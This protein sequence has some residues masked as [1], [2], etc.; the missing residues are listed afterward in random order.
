MIS[1]RSPRA[2]PLLV[3]GTMFMEQLDGTILVTALP[4]IAHSF[5]VT[6]AE[7]DL[8]VSGYL[9][10]LAVM[11]PASG[12]IAD[13]FGA[14]R[15]FAISIGI[16]VLA[17]I[18]C[19]LSQSIWE[20]LAARILQGFGGATMVPVGRLIVLRET[21]KKDLIKAIAYLTW[22][23]LSAPLLGPPLGGLLTTY[24]SWHWI[25]YINVPLGVIA[26]FLVWKIVPHAKPDARRGFD[27]TSFFLIGAA[28]LCFLY[29]IELLGRPNGTVF[30]SP[31]L[32]LL[33]AIFTVLAVRRG[34]SRPDPLISF[35]AFKT[36]TFRLSIRGG[37]IFRACLSAVPFLLPLLFQVGFGLDPIA[38]GTLIL[39]IFAGNLGMKPATTWVL[40][41]V[42]FRRAMI[43]SA[44]IAVATMV[45][46]AALTANTPHPVLLALLFVSGLARSMQFTTLS[47]LAFSEVP[48]PQM[49]GANTIFS[50]QQQGAN[51]CGVAIAGAVAR[52]ASY[53]R[54]EGT[55]QSAAD[56]HI[57]FLIIA[58]I[59]LVSMI[60]FFRVPKTA[61]AE[62][63]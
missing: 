44:S 19:G 15:V 53:L 52:L 42:G 45:G 60:D 61:G 14:K 57:A 32:L 25:F 41:T 33:A 39:A 18:L 34:L 11:I 8:S 37:G 56:F 10:T 46:C 48:K 5:G 55:I 59:A 28:S 51:A 50:M 3:A 30:G 1:I 23:A 26:L 21:D 27:A 17:S 49:A 35:A 2:L 6:A 31:T 47:T 13:R 22:P 54:G 62:L 40:R 43:G 16:F 29:G 58:F 12:W 36:L 63:H 7:L 4:N 38:S 9:V 24:A 20:L